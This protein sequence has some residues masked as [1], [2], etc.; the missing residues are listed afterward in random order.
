MVNT[1]MPSRSQLIIMQILEKG[2]RPEVPT[3]FPE[4]RLN[5]AENLL[6]RSD[7]SIAI[8]AGGESGIVH[9]Y[10]FRELREL[11]RQMASAMRQNGL[12]VGD[13]VAGALIPLLR[14][15]P[16]NGSKAS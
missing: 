15:T 2:V 3:W 14:I 9:N 1:I 16:L 6:F 7:E 10:S 4:A 13:R 5:Y 12:V 11:V 8:T